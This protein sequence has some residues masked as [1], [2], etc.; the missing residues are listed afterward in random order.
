MAM[1]KRQLYLIS[2]DISNDKCL[3]EA[4][5]LV[6]AYATGGQLSVHECWLSHAEKRELLIELTEII[7]EATDSLMVIRLDARQNM[8]VMGKGIASSAPDMFY[9]G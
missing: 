7:D 9:L 2:Y 5:K 3:R 6:R 4:L 1:I 8:H